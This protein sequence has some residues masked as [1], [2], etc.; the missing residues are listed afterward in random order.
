MMDRMINN[1]RYEKSKTMTF[2]QTSIKSKL[3]N[4]INF[5]KLI[6]LLIGLFFLAFGVSLSVK[7]DLGVSPISCVP[8]IYSV[9]TPFSLGEVTIVF[10][11]IFILLQIAV[12]RRKYQ[13]IQLLQFLAV[14]FLGYFID[15]TLY[16]I[17]D[18]NPATYIGQGIALLI[19]C[20]SIAF[21]VFLVVKANLIFIPVDGLVLVISQTFKKEFGK[22]KICLD[23]S[24]VTMG[25][26]SSFLFL[27]TL[28]GI[29]EGT[30][31]AALIVGLLIQFYGKVARV[32]SNLVQ[33]KSNADIISA[34]DA[35]SVYRVITISREYGSGGHEIGQAI[36][37]KLGIS[38][39]DKELINITAEK[40]GFTREYIRENE[41][42]IANTLFHELYAQNY[43]YVNDT[44]PPTDTLFLIQSKIIRD[45]C[46]KESCVIVGRC[47]NFILKDNPNC[48]NVFVHANN[49][50]RKSKINN[51]YR[52]EKT[53]S[54]KDLEQSDRQR[55]NFCLKYTGQDWR[56]CSN[57]HATV[58]SSIF[59][60]DQIAD[61]L[62][63][64]LQKPSIT[65]SFT[66]LKSEPVHI[67]SSVPGDFVSEAT[68]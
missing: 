26:I 60:T 33:E 66:Q 43:S 16:L 2:S 1:M 37:K 38:F 12:L 41:Q 63:Y 50:F 35:V 57:Y 51:D 11:I 40:S 20:A 45:I 7:A 15:F 42:K 31:V 29:R 56:D 27:H 9:I 67:F 34:Q 64:M 19:S 59:T 36:A 4:K 52:E 68:P 32:L 49:E 8:Y 65:P 53:F 23:S 61:N 46:S 18:I 6:L 44:L 24:I 5:L 13:Y 62:I 47:A 21:G 28:V 48:F 3:F 10:N 17:S 25:I 22:V 58:D 30:V 55:A 54:D 14:V 39:Y